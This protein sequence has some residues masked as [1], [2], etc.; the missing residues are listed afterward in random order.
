MQFEHE[1]KMD[2]G[3]EKEASRNVGT[4]PSWMCVFIFHLKHKLNTTHQDEH[5]HFISTL[6]NIKKRSFSFFSCSVN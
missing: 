3:G 2:C 5:T 4:L 1:I 6:V